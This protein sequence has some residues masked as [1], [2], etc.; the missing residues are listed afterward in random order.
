MNSKPIIIAPSVLASDFSQLGTECARM[1]KAGADWLHL[2]VMDG[3][4]FIQ[5]MMT[6]V[7]RAAE[8]REKL[9]LDFHIQVDGGIHVDTALVS[10]E[11]GA[12]VLV[13]GTGVF[14]APNASEAIKALRGQ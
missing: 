7:K 5:E 10:R 4:A 3:Q 11:S 9:G 14:K 1:E 2:D 6:K 8:L 13:A 12:N